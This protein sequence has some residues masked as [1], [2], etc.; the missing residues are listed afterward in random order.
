MNVSIFGLG[1]VGA[2]TAG[3]LARNGHTVIGVD[4]DQ[5]KLEFIRAGKA[6]ILEEGVDE[7]IA[8]AVQSGRL[9][10]TDDC[11]DA[12][13]RTDISLVCVGTPSAPD[14]SLGTIYVTKVCDEIGAAIHAKGRFHTVVIRS[15]VAPGTTLGLLRPILEQRAGGPA[16]QAF[17]LAMN[18]EFLREGTSIKDFYDPPYT[19]V[20]TDREEVFRQVCELYGDAARTAVRCSVPAA[21]SI[22]YACNLFHATKITFANEIA[23]VC[24]AS[25]VDSREVMDIVCRDTKLNLSPRYLKPGFAFGGSCLPKDL[26]AFAYL[27]RSQNAPVPMFEAIL[28]SNREQIEHATRRIMSLGSR[29]IALMGISFKEGTDDLRESPLI[30]LAEILIGKGYDVVIFDPNVEYAAL[31]GSN[32]RYIEVHLPHL[33]RALVSAE[34]A[35]KHGEVVVFGHRSG[36][37]RQLLPRIRPDQTVFD[38][39]GITGPAEVAGRYEGLYW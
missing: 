2:V 31:F 9:T 10:V 24:K 34:V 4:P 19:I 5:R 37:Y 11:A 23:M 27:G 6:P 16:G 1:Y 15:T 39:A 12:I 32:K 38:L 35:L 18:P 30:S 17:G 26:R 14:G 3:C 13:A 8:E 20:G 25:G 21:E 36:E 33:K 29:R 7:L 22:K 28:R